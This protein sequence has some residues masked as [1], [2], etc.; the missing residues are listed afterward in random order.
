MRLFDVN[1]LVN[2][3]RPENPRHKDF[4]AWMDAAVN[5]EEAYAVADVVING[6]IRIITDRR[7]Y[8]TPTPL[9]QAL[10]YASVVRNRPN[11]VLIGPGARHWGIFTRLCR[12]AGA[13]AKLVPDAFLAALAIEH[14]CEF[15]SSDRDFARFP[16]LRWR[17]P[18]R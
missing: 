15:I 7:I 17:D 4:R 18:L 5:G 10:E 13:R 11:A 14:G 16:G 3:H 9:A 8:R 6:A 1:V 2:A 12:E